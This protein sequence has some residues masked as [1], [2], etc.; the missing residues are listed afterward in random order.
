MKLRIDFEVSLIKVFKSVI[1]QINKICIKQKI[2]FIIN[3]DE[4]Q[5]VTGYD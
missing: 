2:F 1:S 5:I 4:F 3:D